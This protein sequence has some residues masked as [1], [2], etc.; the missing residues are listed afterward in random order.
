MFG[1]FCSYLK[2]LCPES[3]QEGRVQRAQ[4]LFW[5]SRILSEC[6]LLHLDLSSLVEDELVQHL[7]LSFEFGVAVA[8]GVGTGGAGGSG[9]D[10]AVGAVESYAEEYGD[11]IQR[12]VAV[13]VT[14]GHWPLCHCCSSKAHCHRRGWPCGVG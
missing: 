14:Q 11:G 7:K 13:V 1:P 3:C 9:D 6:Y 8:V 2:I 5:A 4:V 10:T 12:K